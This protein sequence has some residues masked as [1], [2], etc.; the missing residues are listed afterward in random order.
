VDLEGRRVARRPCRR[1]A[2]EAR[3][4]SDR[5]QEPGALADP[6]QRVLLASASHRSLDERDV[7]RAGRI[8]DRGGGE[9]IGELDRAGERQELVLAVEDDDLLS[10]AAAQSEDPHSG[11]HHTTSGRLIASQ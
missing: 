10:E 1:D 5:H 6:A 7:E 4:A 11:F 3:A 8:V 9:E 2:A